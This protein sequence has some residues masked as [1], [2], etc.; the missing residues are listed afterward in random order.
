MLEGNQSEINKIRTFITKNPKCNLLNIIRQGL[1]KCKN[2]DELGHNYDKCQNPCGDCKKQGCKRGIC[3]KAMGESKNKIHFDD[4]EEDKG[5]FVLSNNTLQSIISL[6]LNMI[7]SPI[8][9]IERI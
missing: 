1:E 5:I 9:K 7:R 4:N 2:C 8:G 6:D 3:L